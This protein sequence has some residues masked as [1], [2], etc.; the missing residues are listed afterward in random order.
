MTKI[1]RLEQANANAAAFWLAQARA[2]GW[3]SEQREGFAAV[4][5]TRNETDAHRAVVTRPYGT[6]GTGTTGTG[7]VGTDGI[8]AADGPS[9]GAAGLQAELADL[10]EKWGTTRIVVEDPYGGLDFS[11]GGY[12]PTRPMAVMVREPEVAAAAVTEGAA[13]LRPGVTV[14]EVGTEAELAELERVVVDGFPLE[15]HQPW[16]A[17]VVLSPAMLAESGYRAWLCR[18]EGVP[19]AACMTYDDGET[20]GVYWVATLP[21]H[22]SLGLGRAVL[23]T[24]L[25]AQPGRVFTLVATLLGEP[26]Y[27]RLGFV[28]CGATRWWR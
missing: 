17:G 14:E 19:A 23:S 10:F 5:C 26:L 18:V 24:A 6:A 13:R 9:A 20:V 25:A 4:R 3:E 12:T 1:G 22:R 8:G 15:D 11:A 28:E 16:R 21:S 27:R 2:H 7:G